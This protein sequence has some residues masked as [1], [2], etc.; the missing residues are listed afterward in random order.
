MMFEII[1][2][3]DGIKKQEILDGI[4]LVIRELV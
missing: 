1:C 4:N 3:Y 2:F